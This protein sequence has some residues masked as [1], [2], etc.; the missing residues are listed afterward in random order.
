MKSKILKSILALIV[1]SISP[2]V[3]IAAVGML[4]VILQMIGGA[5]FTGGVVSFVNFIYSLVPLY[6][7]L[8][9]IPTI[10]VL[11]VA[12]IKNRNKLIKL[13]VNR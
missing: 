9:A 7:Y 11:A 1:L 5:T 4:F 10:I 6:P 12:I 8:T 13:F 2:F 3:M